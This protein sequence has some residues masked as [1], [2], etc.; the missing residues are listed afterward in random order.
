MNHAQQVEQLERDAHSMAIRMAD[1]MLEF[2]ASIGVA[3]M[4]SASLLACVRVMSGVL[5]DCDNASTRAMA[6]ASTINHLIVSVDEFVAQKQ[7][8]VH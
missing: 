4:M 5:G 8:P 6:T 3:R 1:V 7:T 2:C